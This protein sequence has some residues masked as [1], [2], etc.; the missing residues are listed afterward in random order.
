MTIVGD[1]LRN[2][3]S[4]RDEELHVGEGVETGKQIDNVDDGHGDA[5]DMMM[6]MKM[7]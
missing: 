1:D 7:M 5:G 2:V 3:L 4:Q 6:I